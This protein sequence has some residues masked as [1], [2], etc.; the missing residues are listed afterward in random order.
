MSYRLLVTGSRTWPD[1]EKI[2]T[3]L[4]KAL[5]DHPDDLVVVHGACPRGADDIAN[6]W[7]LATHVAVEAYPAAWNLDG[8][9]AGYLRNARMVASRPAEVLA[10]IHD[11]SRG[12]THCA[13]L[14]EREG[15]PVRRWRL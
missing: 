9:Q 3:E 2:E 1:H 11:N 10:F 6:R 13:D 14:A 5:A 7:A 15:L 8:R 12:A 4:A